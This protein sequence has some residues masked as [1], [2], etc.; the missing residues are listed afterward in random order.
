[1]EVRHGTLIIAQILLFHG[2][3]SNK[4]IFYILKSLKDNLSIYH[5]AIPFI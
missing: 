1:M 5:E 2:N 4:E 3:L